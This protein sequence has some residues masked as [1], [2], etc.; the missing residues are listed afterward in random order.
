MS[1]QDP[2]A[3][4]STQS[5]FEKALQNAYKFFVHMFSRH[6]DNWIKQNLTCTWLKV[7]DTIME[8]GDTIQKERLGDLSDFQDKVKSG[9][10]EERELIDLLRSMAKSEVPWRDLFE[11]GGLLSSL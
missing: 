4:P 1:S 2:S 9:S 11:N 10:K 3:G 7:H 6:D 8:A 5:K